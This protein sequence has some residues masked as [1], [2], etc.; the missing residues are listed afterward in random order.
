M[1]EINYNEIIEN[2]FEEPIY[3]H[4]SQQILYFLNINNGCSFWDIIHYVG[5]SERR[6]VRLLDQMEKLSMIHIE[7]DRFSVNN[8]HKFFNICSTCHGKMVDTKNFDK[9]ITAK[10]IDIYSKK[11][12][13]TFIFDQR[14]V[15]YETTINRVMYMINRMDIV[16]KDVV[17]L[18]DDDLTGIALGL[19][20]FS[21][22]I[23]VLDIDKRI[24]D[25]T[26]LIAK[27][28][29]LNIKAILFDATKD[30]PRELK[31]RFDTLLFDPTPEPIPFGIFLN[32][33]IE[34]CKPSSTI[35]TSIYSTA[36]E[37]NYEM[38]KVIEK[39]NLHITDML[40]HWTDY[41][42]IDNLY[43][44]SDLKLF[45]KYKIKLDDGICFTETFIRMIKTQKTKTV[46]M[47]INQSDLLGKATKRVLKDSK[48]D[49]EI[50]NNKYLDS[51]LEKLRRNINDKNVRLTNYRKM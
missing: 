35:Y 50:K 6:V 48:E 27:Q 25:Y 46:K 7:N 10:F 11:P 38:Q 23:V 40:P 14:P 44:Q 20:G 8:G 34:L 22:S 29:D 13:P 1:Q 28:F 47:Q 21:K 42:N 37:F 51:C 26:N 18:G 39:R 5:G 45:E 2:D 9:K 15:T 30:I 17:M 31:N 32:T 36:M 49:V 24:V 33:A 19:F 3:K 41:K 4:L 16:G 12:A 43:R